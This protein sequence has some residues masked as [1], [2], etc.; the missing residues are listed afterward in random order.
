MMTVYLLAASLNLWSN[1]CVSYKQLDHLF[2]LFWFEFC[3]GFLH[4][5][6]HHAFMESLLPV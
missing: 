5:M 1:W 3:V 6:R 4:N 2:M